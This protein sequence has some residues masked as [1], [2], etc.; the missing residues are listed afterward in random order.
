[1]NACAPEV[2]AGADLLLSRSGGPLPQYFRFG[3]RGLGFRVGVEG[4]IWGSGFR[5]GV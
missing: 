5:V 2:P 4:L 1:M 3:V